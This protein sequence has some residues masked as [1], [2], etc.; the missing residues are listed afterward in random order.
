M[1]KVWIFGGSFCCGYQNGGGGRDWIAQLDADV[2]VWACTP[3]SPL[4]QLLMLKHALDRH[5]LE[6]KF[7]PPDYILYD[8]PPANRSHIPGKLPAVHRTMT[9]YHPWIISRTGHDFEC[10][11]EPDT[12]H[13]WGARSQT[14][15]SEWHNMDKTPEQEQFTVQTKRDIIN[16]V[17]PDNNQH[18][19]T[20]RA[21]DLIKRS[22]IPYYWYSH[23]SKQDDIRDIANW[24][25]CGFEQHLHNYIEIKT[26][27]GTIPSQT[28]N[29][30]TSNH[31]SIQ[32]NILWS[33]FFN[34]LII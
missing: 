24:W 7:S 16:G 1:K 21:L 2:T 5:V 28:Y 26:L 9:N 10:G 33:K 29:S 27:D 20:V 3:Q 12:G 32:Q 8:Y 23:V 15:I 34:D 14:L 31:L 11:C 19:H 17:L 18:I 25:D 22:G 6:R 4:S 30:K 13:R